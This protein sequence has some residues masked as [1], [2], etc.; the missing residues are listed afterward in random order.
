MKINLRPVT[1]KNW[2][3]LAALKVT[4]EQEVFIASNLRSIALCQFKSEKIP[5]GIYNND[6]PVGFAIIDLED[7]DISRFMI[8]YR[9]QSQGIGQAAL[10]RIIE[11]FRIFGQFSEAVTSVIPENTAARRLYEKIGFRETGEMIGKEIIMKM[12]F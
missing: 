10:E 2:Q 6:E 9:Y 3:D 4:P 8:D 5:L 11:L 1:P 12:S 7:Y